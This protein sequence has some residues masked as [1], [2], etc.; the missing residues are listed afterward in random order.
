LNIVRV[1]FRVSLFGGG[2]DFSHFYSKKKAIIVSFSIDRYCYISLRKLLPYF[3]TKYRLSWSKIEEVS[4]IGDLTHPSVKACLNY[5]KIKDPLEI[6]TVGDLPA[7]SGLGSSSAFTAALLSVLHMYKKNIF[8]NYKIIEETIH[9][10]QN[11]LKEN[12]GIQDQIQVCHGGF[13]I[14]SI[15]PDSRYSILSLDK[16]SS[17]VREI[18]DNLI[19]LYSGISRISS[20]IHKNQAPLVSN[21]I[22]EKSLNVINQI[23]EE[24]SSRLIN[25]T[26]SFDFFIDLLNE[27]WEAKSS[28]FPDSENT[29]IL[30]SIYEQA[31]SA[32]A[33]SGKLL[34]A[35]GGGF[36]AFFV[37][38]SLQE[39][40][41][42]KMSKYICVKTDISFK[43]ID[44]IL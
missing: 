29:D 17:V 19:I 35:G 13:N 7:R 24:F 41:R 15:F 28:A 44:R 22:K 6:H 37:K 30:L 14:T 1:P 10:E 9:I 16:S 43:G 26:A 39:E 38:P 32:G 20:D 34:G 5:L 21:E 33:S 8:D 18:S 23:A 4:R 3:N 25:H 40:F 2:T 36:F 42:K 12:V 11:I 27:S 31:I